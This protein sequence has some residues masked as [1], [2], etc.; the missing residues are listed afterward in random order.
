MQNVPR[1]KHLS[2]SQHA[3]PII[4]CDL[5]NLMS[6]ETLPERTNYLRSV[7]SH[8]FNLALYLISAFYSILLLCLTLQAFEITGPTSID[9]REL[10]LEE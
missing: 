9:N 1:L 7:D 4:A 8:C 6:E 10:P 3:T 2:V 5:A